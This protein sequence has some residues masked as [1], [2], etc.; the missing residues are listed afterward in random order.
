MV[1]GLEVVRIAA[2][3]LIL[4]LATL[5]SDGVVVPVVERSA[6]SRRRVALV[7][8]LNARKC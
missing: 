5:A 6:S 7:R 4:Q 1:L 8:R 2:V 3:S